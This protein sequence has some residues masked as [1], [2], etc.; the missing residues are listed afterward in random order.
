MGQAGALQGFSESV[1]EPLEGVNQKRCDPI[2]A[3]EVQS[4]C[5]AEEGQRRGKKGSREKAIV[6]SRW[7]RGGGHWDLG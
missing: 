3:L 5:S 2:D 6:S 1:E 7:V 4:G